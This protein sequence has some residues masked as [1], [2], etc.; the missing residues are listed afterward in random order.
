M[1]P[2]D[3]WPSVNNQPSPNQTVSPAL[4][5]PSSTVWRDT[6]PALLCAAGEPCGHTPGPEFLLGPPAL[7]TLQ[8]PCQPAG[9]VQPAAAAPGGVP[10]GAI[11]L[12]A[13]PGWGLLLEG[14]LT[15]E[16]QGPV[17][18]P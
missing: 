9:G 6:N 12:R 18:I 14:V 16:G 7:C 13:L 1:S 4:E 17:R 15:E 10:A 3:S 5:P 8:R 11:Y 2:P